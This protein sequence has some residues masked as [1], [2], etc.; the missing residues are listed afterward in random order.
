MVIILCLLLHFRTNK[1]VGHEG[2]D[3]ARKLFAGLYWYW[4][5]YLLVVGSIAPM[6]VVPLLVDL[7]NVASK[8]IFM[9]FYPFFIFKC[10]NT[11]C[12]IVHTT[13]RYNS[14]WVFLPFCWASNIFL[15]TDSLRAYCVEWAWHADLH[16]S[17]L[18]LT[19]QRKHFVNWRG[20]LTYTSSELRLPSTTGCVKEVVYVS[21]MASCTPT[22]ESTACD[23]NKIKSNLDYDK[24]AWWTGIT[25]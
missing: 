20:M 1:H 7:C 11:D 15:T 9:W 12:A 13:E 19:R 25:N 3:L 18:L 24:M 17:S 14:H 4:I 23:Q 16:S 2:C 22:A 5:T 10:C 21:T 8:F 6:F